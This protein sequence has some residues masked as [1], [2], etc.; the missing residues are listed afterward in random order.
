[1]E[2]SIAYW[3]GVAEMAADAMLQFGNLRPYKEIVTD[4]KASHKEACENIMRILE[5]SYIYTPDINKW[6]SV[7]LPVE[8]E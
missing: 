8:K 6:S 1:M 4:A 2:N 5:Q 3:V 7:S